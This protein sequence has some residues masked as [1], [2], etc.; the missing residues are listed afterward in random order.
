MPKKSAEPIK[1][2]MGFINKKLTL[3]F[4]RVTSKIE[5]DQDTIAKIH[6]FYQFLQAEESKE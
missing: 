5:L 3:R 4:S 1:I 2:E 6:R